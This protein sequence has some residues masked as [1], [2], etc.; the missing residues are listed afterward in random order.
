[1]DIPFLFLEEI[2]TLEA[3]NPTPIVAFPDISAIL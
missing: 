1:M 3:D 2:L